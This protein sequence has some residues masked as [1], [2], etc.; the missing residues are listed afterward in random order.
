[1]SIDS[2]YEPQ[3][4]LR[5]NEVEYPFVHESIG[6]DA[7]RVYLCRDDGTRLLLV[8]VGETEYVEN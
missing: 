1:M 3:L 5:D 6:E 2:R 8:R 4:T 7:I